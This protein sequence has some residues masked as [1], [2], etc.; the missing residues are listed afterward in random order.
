MCPDKTPPTEARAGRTQARTFPSQCRKEFH[1]G[2]ARLAR[3]FF[4][5]A[6]IHSRS[7]GPRSIV[8]IKPA[9]FRKV[10]TV[11]AQ[12]PGRS[13]TRETSGSQIAH[14]T[15]SRQTRQVHLLPRPK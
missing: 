4:R 11:R 14:S 3:E 7:V 15:R 2:A 13:A 8:A 5:T 12:S 6:K 10:K 1:S 9:Q